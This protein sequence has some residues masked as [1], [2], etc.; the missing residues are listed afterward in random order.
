MS[1][2]HIYFFGDFHLGSKYCWEQGVQKTIDHIGKDSKAH[3]ILMGDEIESGL[4]G[5]LG[6][7]E[8]DI[9]PLEQFEKAVKMLKPIKNKIDFNLQSNHM[10]RI[11]K[12]TSIDLPKMLSEILDCTYLDIGGI[13]NDYGP[14]MVLFHGMA[15]TT[16]P[17]LELHRAFSKYPEADLIAM[18][19]VHQLYYQEQV[20]YDKNGNK[21]V[22]YYVRTGSFLDRP[23]YAV[24]RFY[25]ETRMG[26][27]IATIKNRKIEGISF[28]YP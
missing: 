3:V 27:P 15:N 21:R 19:H 7:W 12:E 11:Y 5:K 26:C 6:L 17:M 1:E 13:V 24:Q 18:G 14:S 10:M 9:S 8:Q 23:K 20:V 25:P 28:L 4:F 22:V 16:N 2:Q